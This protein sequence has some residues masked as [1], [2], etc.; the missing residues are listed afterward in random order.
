VQYP[1]ILHPIIVCQVSPTLGE[2]GIPGDSVFAANVPPPFNNGN[3]FAMI[4]EPGQIM[5]LFS[6]DLED[7]AVV[8]DVVR[9]P[10][11]VRIWY[12]V[13]SNDSS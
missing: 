9:T 6:E 13:C 8:D 2:N 12:V 4:G 5:G 10:D 3:G 7:D 11:M 1:L